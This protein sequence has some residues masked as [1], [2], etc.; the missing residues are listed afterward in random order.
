LSK[1]SLENAPKM[2]GHANRGVGTTPNLRS[3][4]PVIDK[5]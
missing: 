1:G 5:G 4:D 3:L 2:M